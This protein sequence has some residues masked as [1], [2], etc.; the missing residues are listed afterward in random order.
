MVAGRNGAPTH[1]AQLHVGLELITEKDIVPSLPQLMEVYSARVLVM[2]Q[3]IVIIY[4]V[5]H[6]WQRHHYQQLH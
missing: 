4:P 3:A 2:R 6:K 1:N 5:H